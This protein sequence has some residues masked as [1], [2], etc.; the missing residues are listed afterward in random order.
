MYLI[1]THLFFNVY[2]KQTFLAAC[3]SC[4]IQICAKEFSDMAHYTR[5]N[6]IS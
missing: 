4:T 1:S 3:T 2:E 5:T 6:Q